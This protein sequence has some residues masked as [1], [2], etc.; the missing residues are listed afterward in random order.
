MGAPTEIRCDGCGAGGP[1]GADQR[2]PT[3]LFFEGG[4]PRDRLVGM[5]PRAPLEARLE[6]LL[7]RTTC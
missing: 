4:H 6:S 3:L 5:Q 1:A 2:I 7:A